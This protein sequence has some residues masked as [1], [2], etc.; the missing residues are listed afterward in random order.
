MR[1]KFGI[2]EMVFI[3][4][5]GMLTKARRNDLTDKEYQ[6]IKYITALGRY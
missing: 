6:K 3:G 4:D 2:D 1:E 5:R